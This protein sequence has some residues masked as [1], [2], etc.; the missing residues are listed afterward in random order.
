MPAVGRPTLGRFG[1]FI[2]GVVVLTA[3][4]AREYTGPA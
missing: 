3:M 1:G 2:A 4:H